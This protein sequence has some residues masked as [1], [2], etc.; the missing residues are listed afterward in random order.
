M[1]KFW[2]YKRKADNIKAIKYLNFEEIRNFLG[3]CCRGR[4]KSICV[5][6]VKLTTE[7]LCHDFYCMASKSYVKHQ[8]LNYD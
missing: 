6:N 4:E 7:K 3:F 2:D 1:Y 8:E 5:P